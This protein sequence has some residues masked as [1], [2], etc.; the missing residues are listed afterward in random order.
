MDHSAR[1]HKPFSVTYN[2]KY[3]MELKSNIDKPIL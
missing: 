3:D 2:S 1:E